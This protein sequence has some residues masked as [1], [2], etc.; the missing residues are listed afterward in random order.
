[1]FNH[2][3]EEPKYQD[4]Q[5]T[6]VVMQEKDPDATIM[7]L[8]DES[9][10]K[11][12]VQSFVDQVELILHTCNDKEYWAAVER[13]K[14]PTAD[15]INLPSRPVVYPRP[16]RVVGLFASYKTAVVRTQMGNEC[17]QQ[18]RIAV[19]NDFPGSKMIVGAGIAYA[20]SHDRKFA[21]VLISK[22][23]ENFVPYR[24]KN[25]EI[26]NR[27]PREAIDENIQEFFLNSACDWSD[28]GH[29]PCTTGGKRTSKVH[30]G[31]IVSTP[32][33]ISD[34]TFRDQ[35]MKHTPHAV[36]GEMEGWVLLELKRELKT[37]PDSPKDIEVIVI[38]G[39]ADYG[40]HQKDDKW[41]WT[42]AKA[43]IDC[44]HYCL[45]KSPPVTYK[46]NA[47]S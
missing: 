28:R 3:E 26:T 27:G 15:G 46:G 44:I 20:N 13:L 17:R 16:N 29:F 36:G 25:G 10:R 22:Q 38:K 4:E 31:C 9:Q 8:P 12:G 40:D 41:Q 23:I 39:V 24:I 6:K 43:A 37:Y 45:E 35:L 21:D 14:P 47:M 33:L 5:R 18:L 7:S 2:A 42:A 11:Q 34:E 32:T 19:K 1:M 30:I